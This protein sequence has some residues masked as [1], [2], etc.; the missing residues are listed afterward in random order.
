MKLTM[1]ALAARE[2]VAL[3]ASCTSAMGRKADD[4]LVVLTRSDFRWGVNDR[5]WRVADVI[6]GSID[7]NCSH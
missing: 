2:S 7:R 5:S 3:T 4:Q 1:L 6:A